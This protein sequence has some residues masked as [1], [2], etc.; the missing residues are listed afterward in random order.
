MFNLFFDFK[1]NVRDFALGRY[2]G[3]KVKEV[4]GEFL[5]IIYIY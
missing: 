5:K 1:K 3:S 2:H 4:R